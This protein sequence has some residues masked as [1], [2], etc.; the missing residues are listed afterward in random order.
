MQ[1]GIDSAAYARALMAAAKSAAAK[2][3][4]HDANPLRVLVRRDATIN[5]GG[6]REGGSRLARARA[7]AWPLG[8]VAGA[9]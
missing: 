7:R 3:P 6:A 2:E 5:G 1:V 4:E 9:T 8:S